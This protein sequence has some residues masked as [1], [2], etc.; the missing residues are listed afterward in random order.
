LEGASGPEFD[1]LVAAA[2]ALRND[3]EFGVV[4]NPEL[5]IGK[6][7]PTLIVYKKFDDREVQFSSEWTEA[8]LR[9][10]VQQEMFPLVGGIGPANYSKYI[11]RG[12]PILW[13]F[14]DPD[15]ETLQI[16][17]A[18][19]IVAKEF[20][21]KISV[22]ALDGVRWKQHAKSLGV[23]GVP[24]AVTQVA[25]KNENFV[26]LDSL[27]E[28]VLRAHISG[29]LDG[30]LSSTLKSQDI[31]DKRDGNVTI[32]VG[33]NFEQITQDDTKTVFVMFFAPWCGHCK[34]VLPKWGELAD[35]VA[36]NPDIVIAK[37]DVTANEVRIPLQGVP[38]FML[39]PAG[40]AASVYDG[41]RETSVMHK[42]LIEHL[43]P[44][45]STP[46]QEL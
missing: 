42:F 14:L 37:L 11:D 2:N 23:Q 8:E 44:T 31:P 17:T 12:L 7:S 21:G 20:R 10:F 43:P 34:S 30:K 29:V 32:L 38:T 46:R 45:P 26:V 6:S 19:E 33:K 4:T 25:K 39:F 27:S 35:M 28:A 1:I 3:C 18:A 9:S 41:D 16:I 5:L 15:K 36:D 22:V 40:G 24:G 13:L